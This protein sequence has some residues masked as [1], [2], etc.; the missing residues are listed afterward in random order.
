[1]DAALTFVSELIAQPW[2]KPG[3]VAAAIAMGTAGFGAWATDLGPWYRSLKQ[4]L[5][6]PPD[7]AFPVVW[8]SIFGLC[9]VAG[10]LAWLAADTPGWR[11]CVLAMFVL[12]ALLNGLWSVLYFRWQRPDWSQV[13]VVALWLSVLALVVGVWPL[14]PLA[15]ALLLPYLVWVA[16]AAAL[17]RATVQL[18]G[19]FVGRVAAA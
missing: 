7:W 3:L 14:S 9:T 17:N 13:E 12:N 6:K 11:L 19:P 1:M 2:F 10:V 16:I 18:N 5:W 15:S 4:P 8:T